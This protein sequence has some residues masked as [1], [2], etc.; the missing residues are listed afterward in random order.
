MLADIHGL[1][2]VQKYGPVFRG[3]SGQEVQQVSSVC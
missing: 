2:I 3:R 1:L